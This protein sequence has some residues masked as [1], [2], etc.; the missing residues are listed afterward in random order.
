MQ[1]LILANT[2]VLPS[3]IFLLKNDSFY[4]YVKEAVGEVP[5]SYL[6]F[7]GI[8]SVD[9]LL[10]V[11]DIFSFVS[12]DSPEFNDLKSKLAFQLN[13]GA[14]V[15][16]PGFK[17]ILNNFIQ[18]LRD[19]QKNNSSRN[20]D[21]QQ[22][23]EIFNIVQKHSLLRSL[24]YFYQVNNINDFSTSFLC[25]L[26]ENTIDNL[27]K[28]KNHYH[29]KK[30]IIDFSISLYILGGR[31]TYEF[32]RNNL[33]CALPNCDGKYLRSMKLLLGFFATLPNINL[34]SDDKCFQIDIPDEWSWYFL[35]RRQLLLFLQDATHLATKW[36][37][38]LLSDIAD[39]TIGNKKANMIHLE[40]IVKTYNNKFDHGLVMSDFDPSDRQNYRS[41]E[42]I[43]SN[44]ALAIL[45]SNH[46]AYAT[47]LHI[48]L[49]RYIIDAFINK[50]TLIR[51]RLYFAWTIVFVCRLWKAW[52]NLEFKSLSQKSKDNYFITKPAYYLIEINAHVLLYFVLLVHEG[53][54]PPESLQ[55]PLFSNQSCES[56]F[57]SSRSLTG[58]QSTMVNFTVMGKFSEIIP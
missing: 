55:I 22:K 35:R 11:D 2:L 20:H 54:L 12:I 43:S 17:H 39:L 16:R 18:I 23:E 8:N 41:C 24:V 29:Y 33:I 37:N 44:E 27:M 4:S 28:S 15:V 46:D 14:F 42:K 49:L 6:K 9:C 38:R 30:P 58:T 56:I 36:R 25:C 52:L 50:S 57:R 31:T 40:N 45:E 3:D 32:V 53:S 26:I 47:F 34:T 48:K 13:N 51:D 5:A 21:E 19:K 10:R 7:L 1:S